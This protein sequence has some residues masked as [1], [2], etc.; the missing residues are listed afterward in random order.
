[1]AALGINSAFSSSKLGDTEQNLLSMR[2]QVQQMF[3]GSADYASLD[4]SLALNAGLV[5][6][7]FIKGSSLKNPFGGDIT[8]A[9]D[10]SNAAFTIE[11]TNIPKEECSKLAKFQSD[12]CG[13]LQADLIS[14]GLHIGLPTMRSMKWD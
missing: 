1:M 3:A 7:A 9:P 4:N 6:K 11:L 5:P 13:N 14:T 8:L 2:M 10:S 12:A